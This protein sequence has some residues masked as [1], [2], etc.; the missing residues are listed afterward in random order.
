M[1]YEERCT[2]A[3]KEQGIDKI[4]N[5]LSGLGIKATSE[6][7][8]GFTMCAYVELSGGKYIYANP[9][10]AG[11]YDEDDFLADIE[12]KDDPMTP[13]TIAQAIKNYIDKN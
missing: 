8:G 12:Q 4:V 2:S 11:V 10:G 9:Y 7:T 6:Q 13:E 1:N 3:S 5:A